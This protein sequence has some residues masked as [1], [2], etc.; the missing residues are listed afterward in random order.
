MI[1]IKNPLKAYMEHPGPILLLAGPGTS[2]TY[3]LASNHTASLPPVNIYNMPSSKGLEGKI[4]CVAGASDGI[5]PFQNDDVE[6]KSRLF[7]VAM[8]K[9]KKEL[10]LFSSRKRLGSVTL[11]ET[12]R[13][14]RTGY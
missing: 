6:E 9:T 14:K 8:T 5:I 12:P 10:H 1:E 2:K 13:R 4:I 11:N 3:Q 7:Y